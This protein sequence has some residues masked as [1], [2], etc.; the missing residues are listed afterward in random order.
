MSGRDITIP[1]EEKESGLSATSQDQVILSL[2]G[3]YARWLGT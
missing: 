1:Q 2:D 3:V